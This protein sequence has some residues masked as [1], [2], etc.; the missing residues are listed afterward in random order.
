MLEE[1]QCTCQ[2]SNRD[3]VLPNI[4]HTWKDFMHQYSFSSDAFLVRFLRL[5]T[6]CDI[7]CDIN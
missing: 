6:G 1:E 7:Y 4:L 2:S 5:S 3:K